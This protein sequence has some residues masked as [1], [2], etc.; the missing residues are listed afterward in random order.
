[1]MLTCVGFLCICMY[2]NLRDDFKNLLLLAGVEIALSDYMLVLSIAT[3]MS[4]VWYLKSQQFS[5]NSCYYRERERL[6][7]VISF[8]VWINI[9]MY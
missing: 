2:A 8:S 1:M 5:D 4:C 9:W 7:D 3:V 6:L